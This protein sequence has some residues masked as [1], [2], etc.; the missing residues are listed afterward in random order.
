MIT[1]KEFH[2][3]FD[4]TQVYIYCSGKSGGSSLNETF[5]NHYN[6]SH[7]H[8]SS[9]FSDLINSYNQNYDL[10]YETNIFL[11]I[12]KSI[13]IYDNIYFI[14]SYRLPL[15]RSISSFFQGIEL[16]L[17]DYKN[18]NIN[19]IIEEYNNNWINNE[20]YYSI[21]EIFN[22][23]KINNFDSIL[24]DFL[25]KEYNYKNKKIHFILLRFEK[26]NEWN[27]ILSNIFKKNIILQNT[28]NSKDKSYYNEYELFKKSYYINEN[29]YNKFISEKHFVIYN[30]EE[31]KD[32]Y[33]NKLRNLIKY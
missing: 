13:E 31:T 26:I 2:P 8:S 25:Y 19:D 30:D 29:I 33:K 21:D 28:N 3:Y 11:Y 9:F 10:D 18:M 1:N 14:D 5:K 32:K 12:E 22:Y 16:I 6:T 7:I 27:E 4:N 24:N 15:E 17:P 23:L 20:D